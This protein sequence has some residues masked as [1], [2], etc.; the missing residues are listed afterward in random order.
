MDE[1]PSKPKQEELLDFV[2]RDLT[3]LAVK[4]FADIGVDIRSEVLQATEK[5]LSS[6]R[7][8]GVG[9][10]IDELLEAGCEGTLLVASIVASQIPG[11]LANFISGKTDRKSSRNEIGNEFDAMRYAMSAYVKVVTRR[12][13]DREVAAIISAVMRRRYTDVEHRQWRKRHW[14]KIKQ[15]SV[16]ELA[17]PVTQ[18]IL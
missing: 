1:N 2:L 6:L 8:A 7:E 9:G 18:E 17:I 12:W 11:G 16:I 3:P 5:C 4:R 14:K 13:H 10:E 15:P